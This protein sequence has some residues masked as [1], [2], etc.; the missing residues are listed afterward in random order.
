MEA[1]VVE[2]ANSHLFDAKPMSRVD[3]RLVVLESMSA[4]CGSLLTKIQ[5]KQY[6]GRASLDIPSLSIPR[7][8]LPS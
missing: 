2:S 3:R 5:I 6:K 1:A 4:E 7:T 8:L